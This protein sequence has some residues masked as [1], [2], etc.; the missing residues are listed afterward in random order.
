MTPNF[1]IRLTVVANG[2]RLPMIVDRATGLPLFHPTLFVVTQLRSRNR[3]SN[4]LE[5]ALRAILIL[6]HRTALGGI[7]L[8]ER[9]RALRFLTLA[10]VDALA[11]EVREP[12]WRVVSQPHE[13]ASYRQ[14]RHQRPGLEV[15]R[16]A[17]YAVSID[18][19]DPSFAATRLRYIRDYLGWLALYH[20]QGIPRG[21]A[22]F[23][24]AEASRLQMLET[25]SARIPPSVSRNI[26]DA[27]EGLPS[28]ARK[29]IYALVD[30]TS[31]NNPWD[32]L[33]VR[34][35]NQVIVLW[36]DQL[37]LRR[38]EL[39]GVRV[40]D[41]NF[42]KQEVLIRRRADDKDDPRARQPNAKTRDRVLPLSAELAEL[43]HRYILDVRSQQRG[44]RRH[45]L[46]FVELRT[47]APLSMS[48]MTKIYLAIRDRTSNELQ[49]LT[50]HV[51]RHTWNDRFSESME[52]RKI[53]P[54]VEQK[55][56][57][58]LMGWSEHSGTAARYTRRYTRAR[59]MQVSLELQGELVAGKR[60]KNAP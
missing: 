24:R 43:T 47:G 41:I 57:A 23:D 44:A 21:D 37:G 56:R 16:G 17:A 26:V 27:R 58:Y 59:A 11:R 35:R 54:D 55:Y 1:Q 51:F 33:R 53:E 38:G 39:L 18:G 46:L 2:E 15:L 42:A 5:Q 7:D 36:A 32:D 45:T 8:L 40:E 49:K 29:E 50:W 6:L 28:A 4:T 22:R 52:E 19:V 31:N 3:A 34:R 9:F 20:M 13:N 60:R 30:P 10:E 48:A 12:L 14:R 25:I